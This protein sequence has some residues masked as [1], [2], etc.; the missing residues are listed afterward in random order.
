MIIKRTGDGEPMA[1]KKLRRSK[2]NKD[3]VQE[4]FNPTIDSNDN[5]GDDG[6]SGKEMEEF[7]ERATANLEENSRTRLLNALRAW[8][9]VMLD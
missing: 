1:S 3:H 5:G 8:K 2:R 4:G 7:F 9:V 6:A